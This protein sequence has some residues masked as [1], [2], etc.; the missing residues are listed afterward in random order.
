MLGDRRKY[1]E[2]IFTADTSS[3]MEQAS[4]TG[5]VFHSSLRKIMH[6][7]V[8]YMPCMH[9]VSASRPPL[10]PVWPRVCEM[11]DLNF[12]ELLF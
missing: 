4:A 3:R 6:V 5:S 9:H 11:L 12:G 7:T 1:Y 8:C 2:K 10:G